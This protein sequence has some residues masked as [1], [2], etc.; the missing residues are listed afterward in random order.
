MALQGVG[1]DIIEIDR[2]A[3]IVERWGD[4]FLSRV[5][6][7]RE[8][9]YARKKG[10]GSFAASLAARFAAKEAVLKALGTG[11]RNCRWLEIEIDSEFGSG[12]PKVILSGEAKKIAGLKGIGC[13]Y[14]SLSHC[15][16]Y[17][18]AFAVAE[19]GETVEARNG[20]TDE[21]TG[22]PGDR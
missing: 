16:D 20:G 4:R 15:H 3:G 6:T 2:V 19:R 21:K 11:L 5:F 22:Q 8:I 13:V 10:E 12:R 9:G 7:P 14:V 18:V 17:A 1:T